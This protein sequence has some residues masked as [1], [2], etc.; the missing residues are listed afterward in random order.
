MELLS[1]GNARADVALYWLNA[2]KTGG[3][4]LSKYSLSD[5]MIEY[6]TKCKEVA[7]SGLVDVNDEDLCTAIKAFYNSGVGIKQHTK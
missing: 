2:A 6:F 7:A 3:L 4:D 1:V 5:V